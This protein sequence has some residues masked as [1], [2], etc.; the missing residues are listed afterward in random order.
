MSWSKWE[1]MCFRQCAFSQFPFIILC[2]FHFLS[3]EMKL[4]KPRNYELISQ[5][6]CEMWL[7]IWSSTGCSQEH[8]GTRQYFQSPS[9]RKTCEFSLQAAAWVWLFSQLHS[10][11]LSEFA[12][13]MAAL[14]I[15]IPCTSIWNVLN[16]TLA[17]RATYVL[18]TA[19]LWRNS[20][21]KWSEG[22]VVH[23]LCH[24]TLCNFM[25]AR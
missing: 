16:D 20:T 7:H 5:P 25:C 14:P 1:T 3:S 19:Q 23:K 9:N 15:R 2:R 22:F 24:I 6:K 18:S 11:D 4:R 21:A 13:H 17:A 12:S 10:F 8:Y